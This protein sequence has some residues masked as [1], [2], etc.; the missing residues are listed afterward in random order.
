MM[1]FTFRSHYKIYLLNPGGSSHADD[2][3]LHQHRCII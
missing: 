3:A 2:P 1:E